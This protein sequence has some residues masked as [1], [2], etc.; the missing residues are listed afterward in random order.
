MSDQQTPSPSQDHILH[1]P[2]A[3]RAMSKVSKVILIWS[4]VMLVLV[5]Y[6]LVAKQRN[7]PA[8]TRAVP[9]PFPTKALE[10]TII[11]IAVDLQGPLS[12][13]YSSQEAT[14][15]AAILN[16]QVYLDVNEA[17]LSSR[18]LLKDNCVYSWSPD[19]NTGKRM[20]GMEKIIQTVELMS[21][22]GFLNLNEMLK[23]LP[24]QEASQTMKDP[25]AI[26]K[27]LETCQEIATNEAVFVIPQQINFIESTSSSTL[28]P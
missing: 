1:H 23:S 4:I 19:E 25:V 16:R 8:Q 24:L 12:C 11:P 14:V 5:L 22:F 6:F 7:Q 9:T 20:C 15:S 2:K 3:V 10:P 28:N 17:S 18:F 26:N 13:H 21:S 27:V